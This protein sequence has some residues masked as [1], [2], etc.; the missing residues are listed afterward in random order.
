LVNYP[1][2]AF[3]VYCLYEYKFLLMTRVKLLFVLLLMGIEF[4][5][6]DRYDPGLKSTSESYLVVEGVLNSGSGA[7]NLML[8]RTF[9]LDDTARMQTENNALVMVEGKDNTTRQLTMS[10]N[11]IYSSPGLGLVLDQEYRLHIVT[12]NGKEYLSDYVKAKKTPLIDT[13]T[14]RQ[15]DKGVQIYVT[16]H[17]NTNNTRYYQW[18]YDETWEIRTLYLSHFKFENDTLYRRDMVND[19]V[20]TCWKYNS[21]T[22][23]FI[24]TSAAFQT[25][26]IPEA[27]LIFIGNEDEKLAVRY[28]VLIKQVG[29]D[30]Q[31]YEFYEMMKKN[32]ESLGTIFDAQPSEIKGNIHSVSDPGEP[33]IGYISATSIEEKRIFIERGDLDGWRYPQYCPIDT[34]PA[35]RDS[36]LHVENSG[37]DI[38]DEVFGL[39]LL[40]YSFPTCVDC[41]KR[42]GTVA[43]PPYW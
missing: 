43:R 23:I 9:K 40:L 7:T 37:F 33:V 2:H 22:S 31:G 41:T 20:S 27:P 32:T 14:F 11:G 13:V 36:I 35:I 30:K 12:A 39:G 16:T 25:D 28:S 17:D 42:G 10:G 29:L 6:R 1:E 4:S 5:C 34:I 18:S 19:D 26:T 24:G 3:G 15:N 8:S 21:S 38:F